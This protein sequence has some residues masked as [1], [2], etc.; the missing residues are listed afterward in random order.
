[1][2]VILLL[3][4][5]LMFNDSKE[6]QVVLFNEAF[7]ISK[8]QCLADYVGGNNHFFVWSYFV[9]GKRQ[10]AMNRAINEALELCMKKSTQ[11]EQFAVICNY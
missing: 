1:M 5:V 3:A 10:Q 4:T 7:V 8:N 2:K 9:N 11:C 6:H